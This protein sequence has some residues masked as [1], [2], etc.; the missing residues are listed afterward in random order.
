MIVIDYQVLPTE[1]LKFP[2]R[3]L[4]LVLYRGWKVKH[5]KCQLVSELNS[6]CLLYWEK[7]LLFLLLSVLIFIPKSCIVLHNASF[8]QSRQIFYCHFQLGKL[9]PCESCTM[10]F[11]PFQ[12]RMN[13]AF[14]ESLH[15]PAPKDA[16]PSPVQG[17]TPGNTIPNEKGVCQR[18]TS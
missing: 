13:V 16:L 11:I 17:I 9:Y 15:L 7:M 2:K 10:I 3:I 1:C 6:D 12:L 8:T 14:L 5:C 18:Q 4:Y